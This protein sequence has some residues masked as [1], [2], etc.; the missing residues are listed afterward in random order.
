MFLVIEIHFLY[1]KF[2][3]VGSSESSGSSKSRVAVG[4]LLPVELKD[5]R[6]GQK[7]HLDKHVCGW[8]RRLLHCWTTEGDSVPVFVDRMDRGTADGFQSQI[9]TCW[10][11]GG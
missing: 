2:G 7:M 5:G 10:I 1:V 6:R 4:R 11:S 9:K 8:L 3:L